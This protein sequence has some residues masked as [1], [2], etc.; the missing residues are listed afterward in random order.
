MPS[1]YRQYRKSAGMTELS[2]R[3]I[4]FFIGNKEIDAQSADDGHDTQKLPGRNRLV[5]KQVR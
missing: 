5:E 4:S 3:L 1:P 2:Y